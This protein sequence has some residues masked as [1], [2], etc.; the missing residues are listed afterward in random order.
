MANQA[1][2]HF[3]AD[4]DPIEAAVHFINLWPEIRTFQVVVT[5]KGEKPIFSHHG[6]GKEGLV[7]GRGDVCVLLPGKKCTI[8]SHPVGIGLSLCKLFQFFIS[9]KITGR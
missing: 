2:V 1:T 6:I 5:K 3:E 9:E 7:G 4:M 8:N